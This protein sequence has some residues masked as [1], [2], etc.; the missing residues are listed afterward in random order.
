VLFIVILAVFLGLA[1]FGLTMCRLAAGSDARDAVAL[2]EWIATTE[3]SSE[4]GFTAGDASQLLREDLTDAGYEDLGY[5][6]AG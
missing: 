4:A 3:P 1:L 2:A 6:E 5:R